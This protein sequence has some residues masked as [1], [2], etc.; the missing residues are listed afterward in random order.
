MTNDKMIALPQ[1]RKDS[2]HAAVNLDDLLMIFNSS[3]AVLRSQT[4]N[5]TIMEIIEFSKTVALTV[6]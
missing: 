4:E 3:K 1:F 6:K 2:P 5:P